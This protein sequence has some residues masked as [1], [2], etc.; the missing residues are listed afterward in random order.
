MTME[1]EDFGPQVKSPCRNVCVIDEA[2]EVC[3]GC[4]RTRAEIWRWIRASDLE[5]L[6][7]RRDAAA[8][9]GED[10]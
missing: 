10:D 1:P 4:G 3:I 5:K 9:L 6:Q 7:I 8:R 2:R